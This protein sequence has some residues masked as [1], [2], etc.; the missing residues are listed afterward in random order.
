MNSVVQE[1]MIKR[2]DAVYGNPGYISVVSTGESVHLG[3]TYT[4]QLDTVE[5]PTMSIF[6]DPTVGGAPPNGPSLQ[7]TG[8]TPCTSTAASMDIGNWNYLIIQSQPVSQTQFVDQTNGISFV[9]YV[10][11]NP[12]TM[13]PASQ[14][15]VNTAVR[16]GYLYSQYDPDNAPLLPPDYVFIRDATVSRITQE[17]AMHPISNVFYITVYPNQTVQANTDSRLVLLLNLSMKYS[18]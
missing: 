2:I 17:D 6:Y 10:P 4:W 18:R 1:N 3:N 7:L 13:S 14:V 15:V 5:S 8:Q 16:D 12:S 11:T 9:L